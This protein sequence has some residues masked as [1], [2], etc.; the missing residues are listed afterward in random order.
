MNHAVLLH[1]LNSMCK[2]ILLYASECICTTRSDVITVTKEWNQIF[3]KLFRVNNQ[4]CIDDIHM[5]FGIK[6]RY[7]LPVNTARTHGPYVRVVRIGLKSVS[8]EMSSRQ[9][10][11]MRSLARSDNLILKFL[12]SVCS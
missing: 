9:N 6:G 12:H 11:F 4:D 7:A 2:P 8:D 1:L 3:Y 10:R 5:Y